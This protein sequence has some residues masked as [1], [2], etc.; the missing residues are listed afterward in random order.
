MFDIVLTND[1]TTR[2]NISWE[3]NIISLF[4]N[5]FYVKTIC[6]IINLEYNLYNY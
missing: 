6:I 2:P 1:K 4:I 3:Q 5:M